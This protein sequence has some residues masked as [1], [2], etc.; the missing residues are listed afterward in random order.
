MLRALILALVLFCAS[1]TNM[2][3]FD[4]AGVIN[5]ALVAS[6]SLHFGLV[7]PF[8]SWLQDIDSGTEYNWE[9]RHLQVVR[10][11]LDLVTAGELKKVMFFMPPRHSKTEHVT[12]RYSAWRLERDP[13]TPII[14]GAYN[15]DFANDLSRKV[16]RIAGR[17]IALSSE[18]RAVNHW[19][20]VMGGGFRAAGVGA[21]VTGRGAKLILIDDPVKNRE[22][23]E[24]ETYQER[25]WGWYKSDLYT[26]QNPGGC[27]FILQ[28]TRWAQLD[29]AGRILNSKDAPNWTVVRFPAEAE[30]DD[31]LGREV[32]EALC[33]G[34]WPL[35]ELRGF[36]T[37]LGDRD[38]ESLYQQ[39]PI[40]PEGNKF[41]RGWFEI[42][43]AAP[44]EADRVRFWDKA[45]SEDEGDYSA[46]TLIARTK[47]GLFYIEDVVSGQWSDLERDK[48]IKQ[49]AKL[50]A[51]KYGN[52][53]QIWGEQEPAGSGKDSARAFIRMLAG[54]PVYAE[55]S[56]GSKEVRA[57]GMAAQTEAG[58]VK[59]VSGDWNTRFLDIACAFPSGATDD[60][61]DSACLAF[62]K[63]VE[64]SNKPLGDNFSVQH[65]VIGWSHFCRMI[66]REAILDRR[67]IIPVRW[68]KGRAQYWNMVHNY[69]PITLHVAVPDE[70]SD[71]KDCVFIY[72]E[73][74]AT[75]GQTYEEI[76]ED[77][78][79]VERAGKEEVKLSLINPE[80]A[81]QLQSYFRLKDR[82]R[83]AAYEMTGNR[84][85]AG[86]AQ[87]QAYQ[88]VDPDRP[89]PFK[90][91]IM[92]RPRMYLIVDDRQILTP[93]DSKG[94]LYLRQDIAAF[95]SDENKNKPEI[96]DTLQILRALAAYFFPRSPAM[97][98]EEK[99]EDLLDPELKRDAIRK[100]KTRDERNALEYVRYT[101][102]AELSEEVKT[103]RTVNKRKERRA[104]R[105][106]RRF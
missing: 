65:H 66:G 64:I 32:G 56:S 36:R 47:D 93:Y 58:N 39:N 88:R 49:T 77:I 55:V 48:V 80:A 96:G 22:E 53:V 38:Y 13:A 34:L 99:V 76:A 74:E 104:K 2:E 26:R 14:L 6:Q 97:T 98:R 86:I 63:L 19:E 9:Y 87:L 68:A 59:L 105:R 91:G 69:P 90:G 5:S 17:R 79:Q 67:P 81:S 1:L 57:Q 62:N 33:P 72:R 31:P 45:A 106:P 103:S 37:V 27:A 10:E 71:L 30:E 43:D 101:N 15:Q 83:F 8:G 102:A 3:Q 20:T 52:I 16:R 82:L 29:L 25:V 24:S 85:T 54:Y 75:P 35:Y 94:L 42:V 73:M 11:Y 61:I 60:E 92:G 70:R 51:Q 50:D 44:V 28:M 89:H 7:K 100:A 41:K 95:H 23:A 40:P 46:G 21:G 18:H 78:Q 4:H 12:V 84:L